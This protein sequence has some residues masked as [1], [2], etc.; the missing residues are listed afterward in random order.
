MSSIVVVVFYRLCPIGVNHILT[1]VGTSNG[2]WAVYQRPYRTDSD[3]PSLGS[4]LGTLVHLLKVVLGILSLSI[5]KLM[6]FWL[7]G[8]F[9]SNQSCCEKMCEAALSCAEIIFSW[10]LPIY[11]LSTYSSTA[12]N[13]LCNWRFNVYPSSSVEYTVTYIC[14]FVQLWI[15]SWITMQHCTKKLLWLNLE[16]TQVYKYVNKYL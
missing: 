16:A 14:P 10:S 9:V 6:K 4:N 5:M 15:S 2:K 12:V 3:S 11:V 7:S 13:E 8:S 1:S